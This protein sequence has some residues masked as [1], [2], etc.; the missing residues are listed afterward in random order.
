MA[1]FAIGEWLSFEDIVAKMN[2]FLPDEMKSWD[3]NQT[4]S[5]RYGNASDYVRDLIRRDREYVGGVERMQR[6]VTEGLESGVATDFSFE[7]IDA[8]LDAG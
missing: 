6:L 5:G 2:V 7:E 4:H 8:E 3:E 1:N